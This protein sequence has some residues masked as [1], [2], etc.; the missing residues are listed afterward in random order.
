MLFALGAYRAADRL[1][2]EAVGLVNTN[3]GSGLL[4]DETDS[5]AFSTV[6]EDAFVLD[7]WSPVS[8]PLDIQSTAAKV[9]VRELKHADV[10]LCAT[11]DD[12]IFRD[13]FDGFFSA[14]TA[15]APSDCAAAVAPHSVRGSR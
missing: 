10:A 7:G 1:S 6:Q 11:V 9:T 2:Y 12:P 13:G 8:T 3:E 5:T 4:C 15:A 14:S